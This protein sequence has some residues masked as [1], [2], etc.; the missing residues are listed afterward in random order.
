MYYALLKLPYDF[1]F[2]NEKQM[3][4]WTVVINFIENIQTDRC[5][6]E[7]EFV[8]NLMYQFITSI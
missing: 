2:I 1:F 6:R 5:G 7:F 3:K 4:I 8:P